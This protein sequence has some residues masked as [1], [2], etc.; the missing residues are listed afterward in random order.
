MLFIKMEDIC[1]SYIPQLHHSERLLTFYGI[2]IEAKKH[3]LHLASFFSNYSNIFLKVPKV[4]NIVAGELVLVYL[5]QQWFRGEIVAF[6]ANYDCT[7]KLIDYGNE[8]TVPLTCVTPLS[9]LDPVLSNPLYFPP[10]AVKYLLSGLLLPSE[11]LSDHSHTIIVSVLLNQIFSIRKLGKTGGIDSVIMANEHGNVA[12][13]LAKLQV[14]LLVPPLDQPPPVLKAPLP[15]PI[16]STTKTSYEPLVL[17]MGVIHKVRVSSVDTGPLKFSIQLADELQEIENLSARIAQNHRLQ[18]LTEARQTLPC[19]A[20]SSSDRKYYRAV[21][22]KVKSPESVHLY[23]VD[24]GHKEVL[25][26]KNLYKIP[27]EILNPKTYSVRCSLID[28]NSEAI[29]SEKFEAYTK[30]KI[31]DCKVGK[32]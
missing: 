22:S 23:Y 7:V 3:L 10:L 2:N 32:T 9:A 24:Y 8:E 21:I 11:H 28:F 15:A 4:G 30:G 17:D 27:N 20:L 6:P 5:R 18:P 25:P 29:F 16:Q 12:D 13:A 31:F 26:I 14:G 19:I 1:I